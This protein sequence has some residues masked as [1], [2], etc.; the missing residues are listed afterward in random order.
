MSATVA[1]ERG[2]LR[3]ERSVLGSL[4]TRC[5]LARESVPRTP[6]MLF[7]EVDVSALSSSMCRHVCRPSAVP[8]AEC[9]PIVPATR[10]LRKNPGGPRCPPERSPGRAANC[11]PATRPPGSNGRYAEDR[12]ALHLHCPVAY[13]PLM[14]LLAQAGRSRGET[15]ALRWSDV[16][17]T[18]AFC[19]SVA[20]FQGPMGTWSSVSPTPS[21][22]PVTRPSPPRLWRSWVGQ[23]EPSSRAAQGGLD[24]G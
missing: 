6:R 20:R 24:L 13:A 8:V 2:T 22:H 21:A 5:P 18:K 16:D 1:G 9:L 19:G 15:L 7:G 23:G 10:G 3:G 12:R 14:R 17:L 11:S 4:M